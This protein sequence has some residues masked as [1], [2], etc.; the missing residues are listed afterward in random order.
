MLVVEGLALVLAAVG[1]LAAA[2]AEDSFRKRQV[3]YYRARAIREAP[4]V[5]AA[6]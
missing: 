6:E 3:R 5:L 2:A 4:S 1:F